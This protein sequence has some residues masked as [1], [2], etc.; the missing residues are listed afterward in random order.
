VR[1]REMQLARIATLLSG[2]SKAIATHLFSS[3]VPDALRDRA[4]RLGGPVNATD[5]TAG[6]VK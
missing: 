6:G 5:R 4:V 1:S 2:E 3:R